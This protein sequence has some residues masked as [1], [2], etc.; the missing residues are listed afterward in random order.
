[1]KTIKG[2]YEN[3]HIKLLEEAPSMKRN[4]VLITFLDDE[5]NESE[6]LRSISLQQPPSFVEYLKD[7][8][9][10]LYQEFLNTNK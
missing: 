10:D 8:N 3:G 1:M 2:E 6:V 4:K 5:V 7:E 9:E